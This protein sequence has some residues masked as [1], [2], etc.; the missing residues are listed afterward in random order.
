MSFMGAA[1]P[2]PPGPHHVRAVDDHEAIKEIA[3]RAAE[4]AARGLRGE[5]FLRGFRIEVEEPS[6]TIKTKEE[7]DAFFE[8]DSG[9]ASS[10]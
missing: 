6:L 3:R 2:L 7:L 8:S 9:C 5:K 1:N 4:L 10:P